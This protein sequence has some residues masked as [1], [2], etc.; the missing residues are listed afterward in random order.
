MQTYLEPARSLPVVAEVEVLVA[1]GGPAGVG[2]ALAAA[3]AG[4]KTMLLEKANALGGMATSGMMSHWSGAQQLPL[5]QEII[6][7]MRTSS[8]LPPD[9]EI[10]SDYDEK[11]CI[12]HECQK[13]ALA[14]L[15]AEAAVVVQ[16]HTWVVGV[17]KEGDRVCGVI[18]ESK[19][20]REVILAKVV[21]DATGD[22]DLAAWAGV[23]FILGREKDNCCQP[24]TLMF[25]IGGV[26]YSR[27]IFPGSFESY[28]Q[29]PKGEVQALGKKHLPPPA[30]H[31]LLYQT[32]LPGEVCVN[33]TNVTNIDGTD[34]RQL[35][36]A[37]FICRQQMDAIILFLREFVPG[38]EKCYLVA[39]A[40]NVGVR[41]TRHC[42]GVYTI[43]GEDILEARVFEDWI[44][45]RNYF[46]FDIHSLI[47]PGLD[48]NGVQK[49]FKSKGT[50]TIPYRAC[51]PR[52]VDG[53]LFAGRNIS[54]THL[55]HSNF[56]VMGICLGIGQGVGVAAA[57]AVKQNVLPRDVDIREVQRI[58]LANG[59]E[60]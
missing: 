14:E 4:A 17:I 51:L 48:R 7:R 33:M 57:V 21:I 32:R 24:V 47:G 50:Y 39:A 22:G 34:V 18:T 5:L 35:S 52:K 41:E 43:T 56:R 53:L 9:R 58:L 26:D 45:T 16:L 25:R 20:G 11:W 8:S 27:A 46:N 19:S 13:T 23:E 30:G 49:H 12:S 31:V 38:Y 40:E 15:L 36:Q 59:V 54:G 42:Q 10:T 6:D 3:R 2:A 60:V 29:I 28:I 37:E 44:A 1:G 55:A